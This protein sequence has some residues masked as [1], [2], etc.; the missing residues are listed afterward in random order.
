MRSQTQKNAGAIIERDFSEEYF[1]HLPFSPTG[2][3]RRAV[4]EAMRDMMSG[5]QMNRLLQGD[6]GS[7]KTAVAAA[8]VYSTAKIRCSRLSWHPRRCSPNSTTK[9]F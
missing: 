6:V 5:R 2:A 3:Q 7:G 1:S 4:K 8:L 9:L